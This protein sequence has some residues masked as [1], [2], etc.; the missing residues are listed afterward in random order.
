MLVFYTQELSQTIAKW[1]RL[2]INLLI[3][4]QRRESL[5]KDVKEEQFSMLKV[6]LYG[7]SLNR[8]IGIFSSSNPRT[9]TFK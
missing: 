3:F 1:K 8:N 6:S 4:K 9:Q 5:K 7:S 2:G